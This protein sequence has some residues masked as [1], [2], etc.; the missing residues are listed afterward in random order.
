MLLRAENISKKYGEKIV[1][2]DINFEL[3][4]GDILSVFGKN[5]AGKTTLLKIV[6]E[7]LRPD[8][9]K[10]IKKS[11]KNEKIKT[12]FV[13]HTVSLYDNLTVVENL[14]FW[15]R[16]YDKNVD[17]KEIR[18]YLDYFELTDY[19]D[20]K[21]ERLSAGMRKKVDITRAL[22]ISPHI[23]IIDE[24]FSNIDEKGRKQISDLINTLAEKGNI[25]V[26][27]SPTQITLRRTK[28]IFLDRDT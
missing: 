19:S 6:A 5:G 18:R 28:E 11:D 12:L 10:I 25:I 8:S 4:G 7:I 17:E 23:F 20:T 1:L 22:I 3:K 16:M 14:I 21:V 2:R 24:P 15:A 9:G 13:G 26:F 27:S